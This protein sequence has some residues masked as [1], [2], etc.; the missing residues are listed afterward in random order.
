MAYFQRIG[1]SAVGFYKTPGLGYSWETNSGDLYNYFTWGFLT[2]RYGVAVSVVQIDCL[3]GDHQV[4]KTDLIM[5]LGKS[6]NP[7]IDIGQANATQ[8]D[9]RRVY[10]GNRAVYDGANAEF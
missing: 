5:D 1:M 7:S 4:L 8:V 3:T 2:K 9:R 6:I 10:A